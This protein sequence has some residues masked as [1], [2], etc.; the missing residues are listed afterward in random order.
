M[1]TIIDLVSVVFGFLFISYDGTAT[2]GAVIAISKAIIGDPLLMIPVVLL[3]IGLAFGA[4]RRIV[5]MVR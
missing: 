4:F 2:D 3:L 1:Q 5:S